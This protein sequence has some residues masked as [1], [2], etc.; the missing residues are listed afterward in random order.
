MH[1]Y[2]ATADFFLFLRF[3]SR[4]CLQ[5]F[6]PEI[7]LWA[8]S[9]LFDEITWQIKTTRMSSYMTFQC[10]L[11]CA[12]HILRLKPYLCYL[13][14]KKKLTLLPELSKWMM[15]L[16]L[17]QFYMWLEPTEFNGTYIRADIYS[18]GAQSLLHGPAPGHGM[19][20]SRLHKQAKPHSHDEGSLWNHAP[21]GP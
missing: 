19:L 10:C 8:G 6:Q 16:L 5:L 3:S 12:K 7:Y 14:F 11:L 2:W 13:S 1:M 17:M 18:R 15:F 20:K 4:N 21:S 9:A